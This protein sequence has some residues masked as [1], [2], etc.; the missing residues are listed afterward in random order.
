MKVV[1]N[2][3]YIFDPARKEIRA[4]PSEMKKD[5]GSV[6]TQLQLGESVGMPD[7]R[8][9]PSIAKGA[10]EIRMKDQ[11]GIYRAFFVIQTDLGILVF[12]GF[13]KK[14][15]KTPKNEIETG[16]KRLKAFLRELNYE[17]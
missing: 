10:S 8:S 7:V 13:K 6:L 5:L 2:L 14:T 15:Q 3:V 12:H 17:K 16:K 1:S 4:W 9:M 11:S